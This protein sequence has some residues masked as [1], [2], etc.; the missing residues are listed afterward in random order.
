[1]SRKFVVSK[2]PRYNHNIFQV[3]NVYNSSIVEFEAELYSED[4]LDNYKR[5]NPEQLDRE[6]LLVIKS[7]EDA[8]KYFAELTKNISDND[9]VRYNGSAEVF[10]IIYAQH[11][12]QIQKGLTSSKDSNIKNLFGSLFPVNLSDRQFIDYIQQRVKEIDQIEEKISQLFFSNFALLQITVDEAKYIFQNPSKKEQV[13]AIKK[14]IERNEEDFVTYSKGNVKTAYFRYPGIP[15]TV[16][17]SDNIYGKESLITPSRLMIRAT[18]YDYIIISH[19]VDNEYHNYE[20]DKIS[21]DDK[22]FT[23]IED[24]VHYLNRD[25]YKKI[26]VMSCNSNEVVFDNTDQ[27]YDNTVYPSTMLVMESAENSNPLQLLLQIKQQIKQKSKSI[28]KLKKSII[29]ILEKLP[30]IICPKDFYTLTLNA[31]NQFKL[32]KIKSS[33]DRPEL[34]SKTFLDTFNMIFAIYDDFISLAMIAIKT[35]ERIYQKEYNVSD[36]TQYRWYIRRDILRA[37]TPRGSAIDI[38]PAAFRYQTVTECI[39]DAKEMY[40]LNPSLYESIRDM[41]PVLCCCINDV[42][43]VEQEIMKQLFVPIIDEVAEHGLSKLNMINENTSSFAEVKRI[44]NKIP[45]NEHHWFYHGDTFKDS[46][47]VKYRK[48]MYLPKMRGKVGGFI[49]VYTFDSDPDTGV[50]VIALMPAARGT[51]LSE[52]LVQQA[53]KDVP[54][55]GIKRLIWRADNDNIAS[56]KLAEKMGFH[57]ISDRKS[58]PD[59]YKFEMTIDEATIMNEMTY[60][61]YCDHYYTV[62]KRLAKEYNKDDKIFSRLTKITKVGASNLPKFNCTI[63]HSGEKQLC[64]SLIDPDT[65][66]EIRC[67]YERYINDMIKEAEKDSET[68]QYPAVKSIWTADGEGTIYVNLDF[69]QPDK[70]PIQETYRFELNNKSLQFVDSLDEST[71]IKDEKLYPVYIMLVH[72]GTGVSKAIK[73]ISHSTYSHASI[74]FDSSMK[75]MYSFARKDPRNPFIGGFRYETIGEG[76]YEQKEI[77]YAVYMVPCTE[78]QIKKMKKRLAY[79]EKNAESFTFDFSGLITNYLGIVNNP[80]HRWFCSRFVSDI[81]NAGAPKKNPYVAEPSLQDPDDFMSDTYA[82]YITSGQNLMKYSKQRVDRITTKLLREERIHRMQVN[83]N[84]I[85]N[86]DGNDNYNGLILDYKLAVMD[87]SAVDEFLSYLKSFRIQLDADGNIILN[88]RV[89]RQLDK[90][91]MAVQREL[92]TAKKTNDLETIKYNLAK[93]NYMIGLIEDKYMA[94]NT[95]VDSKNTK[96]ELMDLRSVMINVFQQYMDYTLTQDPRFNFQQY[97]NSSVYGKETKLPISGITALGKTLLT[98]L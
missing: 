71:H 28:K 94:P 39:N 69:D 54:T 26:C 2:S 42:N 22:I 7:A 10:S 56:I 33:Y 43:G 19:G 44:V 59:Q 86:I 70:L 84:V 67:E 73:T 97:Y 13:Q 24:L 92:R 45:K 18:M 9:P 46:P 90:H 55:L 77:P 31:K 61:D 21:F 29:K 85:F 35:Y 6:K 57:D 11:Y 88:Q 75:K 60:E 79:F 48:T 58:N 36:D 51:G 74:S 80:E 47:Y 25:G 32:D 40:Y 4:I 34:I 52:K 14:H 1:M 50:I 83:E 98:Q 53:I 65:P 5:I 89:Y 49:D 37:I 38:M 12:N 78:A 66:F 91:F 16:I 30:I 27:D 20:I 41:K 93:L 62:F 23:H 3:L 87:E 68:N 76:F 8:I 81:L 96:R 64:F 15:C 95:V 17:V 72:S 63:Q 82:H